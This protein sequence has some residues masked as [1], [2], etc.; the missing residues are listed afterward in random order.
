[1]DHA[2]NIVLTW[3]EPP[4]LDYVAISRTF[5]EDNPVTEPG[6]GTDLGHVAAPTNTIT[7]TGTY[8]MGIYTYS[9]FSHSA[10]GGYSA[11]ATIAMSPEWAYPTA[12]SNLRAYSH[13]KN[14]DLEWTNPRW[15]D[16]A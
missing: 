16:Y 1:V 10:S 2:N 3:T 12:T 7:D 15:I 4:G 14:V 9:V 5:G 13:A 6:T 8:P 11:A